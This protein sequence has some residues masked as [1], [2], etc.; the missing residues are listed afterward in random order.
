MSALCIHLECE[1]KRLAG[2]SF[3]YTKIRSFFSNTTA[4]PIPV[5]CASDTCYFLPLCAQSAT[6]N[7]CPHNHFIHFVC[8]L[9]YARTVIVFRQLFKRTNGP[10]QGRGSSRN[11][12]I[13]EWRGFNAVAWCIRP[14]NCIQ[15]CSLLDTPSDLAWTH[16]EINNPLTRACPL[17]TRIQYICRHAVFV[18]V[19]A[20]AIR[21]ARIDKQNSKEKRSVMCSWTSQHMWNEISIWL[22]N[23]SKFYFRTIQMVAIR[24]R[25][26]F[27]TIQWNIKMQKHLYHK[28]RKYI[29]HFIGI[30]CVDIKRNGRNISRYGST[31][32]LRSENVRG[33]AWGISNYFRRMKETKFNW[34]AQPHFSTDNNGGEYFVKAQLRIFSCLNAYPCNA[35]IQITIDGSKVGR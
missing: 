11:A 22:K 17:S 9:N 5:Y 8:R 2:H 27:L 35:A 1:R 4:I 33:L 28:Q 13:Y 6:E 34:K 15:V 24:E 12:F 7:S 31:D 23:K 19:K 18:R 21:N 3:I 30:W 32:L 29:I 14:K 20:Y 10:H 25:I 16:C 26:Y